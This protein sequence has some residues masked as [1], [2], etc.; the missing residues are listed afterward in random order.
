[1]GIPQAILVSK[2]VLVDGILVVILAV[3]VRN[4]WG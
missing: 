3:G 4:Y 1:M 2:L